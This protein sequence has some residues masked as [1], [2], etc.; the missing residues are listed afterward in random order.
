[1]EVLV[2][3]GFPIV[4]NEVFERLL[5]YYNSNLLLNVW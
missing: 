1:M 3:S 2:L 5:L 4:D